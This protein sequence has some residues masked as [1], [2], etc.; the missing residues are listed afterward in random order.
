MT[1]ES[2]D[3]QDRVKAALDGAFLGYH[4]NEADIEEILH[5]LDK[6]G[7]KIVEK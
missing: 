3:I 5:L 4:G 6:A 7:L 2:K 1:R